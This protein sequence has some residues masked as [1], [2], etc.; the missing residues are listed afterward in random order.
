MASDI[1][2]PVALI[3]ALFTECILYGLFLVTFGFC[4]RALLFRKK[5]LSS[6]LELNRNLNRTLLAVTI[7]M[8]LL[9]TMDLA[10]ELRHVLDVFVFSD[11]SSTYQVVVLTVCSSVRRT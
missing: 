9:S 11:G 3:A 6:G 10:L 5:G 4:L 7:L 1:S 8:F 2:I